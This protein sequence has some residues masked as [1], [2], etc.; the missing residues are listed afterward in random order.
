MDANN[1]KVDHPEQFRLV[2]TGEYVARPQLNVTG[3]INPDVSRQVPVISLASGRIVEID[4]RLGD[5]VRKG[6]LLYK[7]RSPD[8]AQAF[9]DY[10]KALVN[11]QLANVQLTRAKDLFE[12][13]AIPKSALE[14]AQNTEDNAKVD[15]DTTLEHLRVLGTDPE[16]PTGVVPVYA[17]VSGV[18]TDQ[19]I[20][21]AAGIQAL[22]S[23][24]PLTISDMSYV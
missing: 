16:H 24:S 11:E 15:V 21:N 18:I 6:Q 3:V 14:Q 7:V 2:T 8:I 17:P 5:E 13:G 10:R 1:F 22:S 20:T 23:P 9:S 4:T 19:Q 12:H